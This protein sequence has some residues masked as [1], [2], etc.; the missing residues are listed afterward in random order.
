MKN[1]YD[2][3]HIVLTFFRMIKT[4]FGVGIKR[5]RSDN[6]RDYFNHT[7]ADFFQQEGIIH[8][9]SCV[10]TPQQNG[11]AERK[12]RHLLD[13]TR[14]ILFH[15]H[16]P[17]AYWGE[18]VLTSAYLINRLPTN[19][20]QFKS[21]LELLNQFFPNVKTTN[22]LTPRI[23]GCVCFVHVHSINRGKLDPR[24]TKC[25]FLGYS[26]TQ[27]GYK[28]YHPPTKKYLISV[29][30]TFNEDE[31]YFTN[32]HVQG[33]EICV[34][35]NDNL[36]TTIS[37]PLVLNNHPI[38][39]LSLESIPTSTQPIISEPISQPTPQPNTSQPISTPEPPLNLINQEETRNEDDP[40]FGKVYSRKKEIAPR[41]MHIHDSDPNPRPEV[42]IT[43][44]PL[45]SKAITS[46]DLPIAI[47]KGSRECTKKPLYPLSNY[48]SFHKFSPAHKSFLMNL[49][50]ISIPR[51]LSEALSNENWKHAMNVEMQAL[52]QNKTWELVDLPN[53]KKTVGCKWVF[54]IKYKEDG[55][56]ERYKARLVAKGYT[57]TYGVDYSE[58]FSPVAKM[59]TVR[60]VL[61]LAAHFNWDI[62]QYDVKNAL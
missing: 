10:N 36:T 50:S 19:V 56:L 32:S 44:S 45:E 8:E 31:S 22:H 20:L 1:K 51:N 12:N 58:T 11:I 3:S 49:N 18:A 4:Q 17:K 40:W 34:E 47:R 16:V 57:Q 14:A 54:S 28:C 15:K 38:N 53:G 30:V 62:Q 33:E 24:A 39:N 26:S 43:P 46:P 60:I 7:L 6:A 29:D 37:L 52:Q 27:K 42:T 13:M 9:S 35:T 59:S 5:F 55:S 21:P 41:P 2:V 48:V 23:F 61:A 25:V